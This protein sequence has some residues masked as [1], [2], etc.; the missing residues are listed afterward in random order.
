MR[1]F[2][3]T[4]LTDGLYIEMTGILVNDVGTFY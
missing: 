2:I 4:A 3:L 1:M